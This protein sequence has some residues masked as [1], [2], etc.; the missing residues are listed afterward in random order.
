MS[1]LGFGQVCN[2]EPNKKGVK[3]NESVRKKFKR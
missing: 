3:K 1:R 2:T